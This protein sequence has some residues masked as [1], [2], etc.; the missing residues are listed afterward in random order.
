MKGKK[1]VINRLN[2]LL[3][4]ELVAADQYFVHARMYH[5]WGLAKLYE[6]IDHERQDEIGHAD[7]LIRRILFLEGTP[8]LSKRPAPTI[9]KDVP[10]ML[11]ADLAL[12][13]QV[14]AELKEAIAHCEAEGDYDT[15]R[16]L[17]KI[18]EDTEQDHTLWLEQQLGLIERMGLPNYIQ[19]AAGDIAGGA[20]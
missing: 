12:E 7:L 15:R 5:E 6:R 18:L 13:I 2:K 3:V 4:G 9:G 20:S 17:G 10:S 19:S 1:S 16:I 8:D 14:I 11:K